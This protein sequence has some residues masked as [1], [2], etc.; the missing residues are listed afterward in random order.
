M[1]LNADALKQ[2][3]ACERNWA[4]VRGFAIYHGR[5]ARAF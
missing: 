1:M 3:V 5:L 2:I 4:K